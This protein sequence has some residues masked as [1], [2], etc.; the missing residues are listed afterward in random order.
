MF[1]C[2]RPDTRPLRRQ[3]IRCSFPS[4]ADPA[5]GTALPRLPSINGGMFF[6][7]DSFGDVLRVLL[8]RPVVW[9]HN[10]WC[11]RKWDSRRNVYIHRTVYRSCQRPH[12]ISASMVSWAVCSSVLHPFDRATFAPD[13]LSGSSDMPGRSSIHSRWGSSRLQ[14][15]KSVFQSKAR[16]RL[17]D[18]HC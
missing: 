15:A 2:G 8:V 11:K 16:P 14:M 1:C 17:A 13:R 10:I 5:V 12:L 4:L 18:G 6:V 7:L 3:R 9:V